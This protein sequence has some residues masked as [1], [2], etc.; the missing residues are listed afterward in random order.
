MS[1]VFTEGFCLRLQGALPPEQIRTVRDLLSVY[2]IGYKIEQIT[3]ELALVDDYQLPEAY[4]VYL[5]AKSQD[6]RMKDG[7][8]EQYRMCLE[9]LLYRFGLPLDQITINHLRLFIQECSRNA[10]TGKPVSR[11]TLNQRKAIIRS[12]FS[13]LYE[14]EYIPKDPSVK[15]KSDHAQSKPRTAYRDTQ[16]EMLRMASTDPRTRA[17]IDILLSS[18]IR[19]AECVGLN[20]SDV[21]LETR[22]LVVFGKGEKWRTTYIGA[23]AVVSLKAYLATRTD[24]NPALFISKRKPYR[25]LSTGQVRKILKGLET[26]AGVEN[27]IPHR[28]RH[29][30]ATTAI[31]A[32]M[33]IES[34]QALLGHT[35]IKT[36]L[37]YAHV[38]N[39]K[40]KAD[41]QRYLG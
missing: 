17:I 16:I 34:V 26:Q 30:T 39:A 9:K 20:R 15:L 41:H 1:E 18:G 6:G 28:F 36:T 2:T 13:W 25:R 29:T 19:I 33:P 5:A 40:V 21:N 14:E 3:T 31:E 27:V 24:E 10:I 38:S 22:E 37:R 35:Q 12:F 4:F 23:A 11:V 32:G 7:T 8:R